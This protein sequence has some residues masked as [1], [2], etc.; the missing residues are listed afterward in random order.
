MTTLAAQAL[1]WYDSH[2]RDL[3]WRAAEATPWGIL[4]SEVMLQQTPVVRV[5]PAWTAWLERWPSPADLAADTP[6]EAIRMWNR[7]GYPRRALRLHACAV[8][9]TEECDG[10]VPS[11]VDRLLALPGIGAYTARA[12]AAFAFGQR[13]PVVDVNV[14]RFLAR[15]VSGAADGGAATTPADFALCESLLPEV[16]AP[17]VSAA[18]MEIGALVCT[19]RAPKCVDCPVIETC[20]WRAAGQPAATGPARKPQGYAGTDRQVRGLMMALLREAVDP[21]PLAA[22]DAVWPDAVQRG[23]ALAGLVEDGLARELPGRLYEL[24]G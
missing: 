20:A 5:L 23:R 13:V 7:L 8:A 12:V 17:L 18:Y 16:D 14:R 19:A 1:T 2:A 24:P 22:L 11:D 3:P 10:V 6:A 4:V 9:I 21:V 15:A